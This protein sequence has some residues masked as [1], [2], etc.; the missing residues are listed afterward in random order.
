MKKYKFI[1]FCLLVFVTTQGV[2]FQVEP[3]IVELLRPKLN[4][5]RIEYLFG[6][7]GVEPLDISSP[8]FPDNRVSNLHSLH[9]GL[10]VMRTLAVVDFIKPLHMDLEG[11][12]AEIVS[13]KSIGT[14]LKNKGWQIKKVPV[15]FSEISLTPNLMLWMQESRQDQAALHIYKLEVSKE[16]F[17]EKIHYCTILEIHS[18]QYLTSECLQ[19]FNAYQYENFKE[20]TDEIDSLLIRC[21]QLLEDFL[22]PEDYA[23]V[24][25]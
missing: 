16:D 3:G 2:A 5:E 7:Y 24:Y 4:S 21:N 14:V 10:K 13:G 11:A 1:L 18:S 25:M 17:P 6:S 12:H 20:T 8:V 22:S 23:K 9:D 19:A 15:Y